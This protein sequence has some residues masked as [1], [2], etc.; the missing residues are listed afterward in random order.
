[1]GPILNTIIGAG[2]K[3]AANLI[4]NWLEQKRHDQMLL[5]AR[6]LEEYYF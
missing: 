3:V 5:A 4:N 2:I 1:M 6:E